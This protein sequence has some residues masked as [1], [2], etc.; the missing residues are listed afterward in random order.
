MNVQTSDH[1]KVLGHVA[2][3]A[4]VSVGIATWVQWLP[5]IAAALS[6]IWLLIQI[7][8]YIVR[9]VHARKHDRRQHDRRVMN[10][11]V[12]TERRVCERRYSDRRK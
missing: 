3:A 10:Y 6:I 9:K 5:P 8:D 2:D 1:A 12:Q 11:V 4:A 7:S